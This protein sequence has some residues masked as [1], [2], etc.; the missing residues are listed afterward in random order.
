MSIDFENVIF[1]EWA[2]PIDIR[3]GLVGFELGC[4][5]V[6]IDPGHVDFRI[7]LCWFRD[8]WGVGFGW[9]CTF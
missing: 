9:E 7:W 6:H 1:Y 8:V 5:G 3:S 4:V 2:Q